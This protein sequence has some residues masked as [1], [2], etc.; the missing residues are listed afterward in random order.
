[1][2]S[3]LLW[4]SVARGRGIRM[5]SRNLR[6]GLAAIWSLSVGATAWAGV[7][8]VDKDNGT[9]PWDG[10][11]WD[12][13]FT[14]I[15]EGIEAASTDATAPRE[16][17]V[18]E[19]VYNE[20]R[21]N[22][23]GS[24]VLRQNV[25]VY[26][27]FVG[28]GGYE[29]ERTARDWDTNVATIDGAY[30]RAGSAAYHVVLGANA[31]VLDG[32]TITGGLANGD[33]SDGQ[34]AGVYNASCSPT[35][36]NCVITLNVAK[37]GGGM[38]NT[39]ASPTV[40]ACDFV[41]NT[42]TASGTLA[43]AGGGMANF[44]SSLPLVTGCT[45]SGNASIF[46][47]A[48]FSEQSTPTVMEC[49][50][51]DNEAL[52]GGAMM[53]S[54]NASAVVT[55]CSFT[56]NI[57]YSG[58]AIDSRA[59]EPTIMTC[60]FSANT[61]GQKGGAV[62]GEDASIAVSDSV[63][64]SNASQEDG[65]A[66][67][68]AEATVVVSNCTFEENTAQLSGGALFG[69]ADTSLTV[70]GS[71]LRGNHA[72][73]HGGAIG[74]ND[75]ILILTSG[76][77]LD[78]SADQDGGGLYNVSGGNATVSNCTF[79]GNVAGG[80]GGAIRNDTGSVKVTNCILWDSAP[81]TIYNSGLAGATV[82]YSDIQGGY[83]GTQNRDEDPMFVD[84]E[85]G[86]FRLHPWSPCVDSGR[87]TVT[88]AFGTVLVDFEEDARGFDGDGIGAGLTGDG[89]DYD[90]GADEYDPASC[91]LDEDGIT[92]CWEES[93][94]L[95]PANGEDGGDDRDSDGLTNAEEF[96]HCTDLD[97]DDS[98][99]DGL[100]D[101]DEVKVYRCDPKDSD[102]DDGG[103]NDG[104]EVAA[105][106]SPTDPDDDNPMDVNLDGAVDAVDVQLVINAALGINVAPWNADVNRDS[107]I[108]A[109][110]VQLVINAALG[111]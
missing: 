6:V 14:T 50:F 52:M 10:T 36:E 81:D 103:V 38:Y 2:L 68:G 17:W 87:S 60:T 3:Y 19:G 54:T 107:D 42:A 32:F 70:K 35:I 44:A 91:D 40:R 72:V 1:M 80:H 34:G 37:R 97:D 9:G 102:S 74:N 58:G 53:N 31:A 18:A 94:G 63:F 30:S 90:L 20:A 101:S 15:Q 78:N 100:T 76:M 64:S 24:L 39:A 96:L 65:G 71:T 27:G 57:A 83:T 66:V 22:R 45:F 33:N 23:T 62:Y 12:T 92:D 61:S 56:S 46:G 29:T 111:L 5:R 13:A 110:D 89:S 109:L 41:D 79:V 82:T 67:Y 55:S 93:H 77:V 73:V 99:D 106:T 85:N 105:G 8:Y 59:C 16:V 21:A 86:C 98:D 108:N 84:P 104:D 43:D 7:W 4:R 25:A 47:G 95:S 49:T 11:S 69:A 28:I 88:A 75:S 51:A 48:M 26:G